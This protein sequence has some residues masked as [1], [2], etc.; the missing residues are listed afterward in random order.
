MILQSVETVLRLRKT[1]QSRFGADLPQCANEGRHLRLSSAH[2]EKHHGILATQI[3]MR[4]IEYMPLR[5]MLRLDL[6]AGIL[7]LTAG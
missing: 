4:I 2:N 6:Q 7:T 5:L 3:K 1:I